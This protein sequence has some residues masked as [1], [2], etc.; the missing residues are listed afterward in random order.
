MNTRSKSK[1]RTEILPAIAGIR[2]NTLSAPRISMVNGLSASMGAMVEPLQTDVLTSGTDSMNAGPG[3]TAT[4]AMSSSIGAS[5]VE[6]LPR[7]ETTCVQSVANNEATVANGAHPTSTVAM[8]SDSVT[9]DASQATI[10]A[11]CGPSTSSGGAIA[12]GRRPAPT[13]VANNGATVASN[14]V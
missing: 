4:C 3:E 14:T 6:N 2:S 10:S 9:S 13:S 5:R 1:S 7:T 8:R 12:K 11:V